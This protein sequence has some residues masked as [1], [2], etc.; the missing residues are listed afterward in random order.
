MMSND[1]ERRQNR[2]RVGLVTRTHEQ[3]HE[4][5]RKTRTRTK[6]DDQLGF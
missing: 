2:S 3:E 4:Q 5:E 1:V 6:D